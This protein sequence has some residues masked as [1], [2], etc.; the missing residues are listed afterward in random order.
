[1][2]VGHND[3]AQGKG[4]PLLQV[5]VIGRRIESAWFL[6]LALPRPNSLL[7]QAEWRIMAN[8]FFDTAVFRDA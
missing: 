8:R 3:L 1:L 5:A 6:E 4:R 7:L 2:H